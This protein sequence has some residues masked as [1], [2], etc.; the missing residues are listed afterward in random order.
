MKKPDK[1]ARRA[2]RETKI[3][4]VDCVVE[5]F[6]PDIYGEK[7]KLKPGDSF[8][9]TTINV[10][11]T[12]MLINCDF[13]LPERTTIKVTIPGGEIKDTK[14]ELKASIV[15]VKRNAYK[16]F[17]RYAVGLQIIEGKKEDIEKLIKHFI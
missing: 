6:P 15:R 10:S 2:K 3:I 13:V 17:G 9:G 7:F 4:P 8:R 14:I 12:G 11:E 5:K 1:E 16:I